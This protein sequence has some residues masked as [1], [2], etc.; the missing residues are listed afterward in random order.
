ME[1]IDMS[2]LTRTWMNLSKAKPVRS[3]LDRFG[4]IVGP[5]Y[6]FQEGLFE[7]DTPFITKDA[8]DKYEPGFLK[9]D[10]MKEI[11]LIPD[12]N[13][14]EDE[15][16]ARLN[17]GKLCYGIK[18]G[19]ALAAFTWC[20]LT[21]C[22]SPMYPFPLKNN[23]AYLFDTYTMPSFRGE[24]IAPYIRYQQYVE[25]AKMGRTRLYSVSGSFNIPAIRFKQKLNARLCKLIL[26]FQVLNKYK[27][28]LVLKRYKQ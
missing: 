20:D 22:H 16:I 11:S 1:R 14:P 21:E 15:L 4:I 12:R 28:R 6:L 8:F 26:Y 13:I 23:E 18:K 5:V 27:L 10:D 9:I 17:D 19:R 3:F 7:E 24:G 2:S 25:L